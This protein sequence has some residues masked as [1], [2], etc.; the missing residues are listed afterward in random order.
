MNPRESALYNHSMQLQQLAYEM[1]VA[2]VHL[3]LERKAAHHKDLQART[4]SEHKA[5]MDLA[6][7]IPGLPDDFFDVKED[8][9]WI[10]K[11]K[12]G[13]KDLFYKHL[14]IECHHWS[15]KTGQA[16]LNKK[17]LVDIIG[18]DHKL[19]SS[20]AQHMM[21]F[22]QWQKLDSTYAV[23]LKPTIGAILHPMWS[24]GLKTT[25]RW[26][27]SPNMQNVPYPIYDDEGNVT[28]PGLRDIFCAPK[29]KW[30]VSA[31]YSAL[32]LRIIAALSGDEPLLTA[33]ANGE[34]VHAQTM[35]IMFGE[36]VDRL[37]VKEKKR[38]RVLTKT[39][40]YAANYMSSLKTIWGQILP[41]FPDTPLRLIEFMH[42]KWF[43]A[44]PIIV[45]WQNKQLF[46]A[47]RDRYTESPINKHRFYHYLNKIKP[48]ICCNFPVQSEAARIMNEAMLRVRKKLRDNEKIIINAHDEMVLQGPE[49]MRLAKLLKTCMEVEVEYNGKKMFYEVEPAIGKNWGEME[50][51]KV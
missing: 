42:N 7:E 2:G 30:L 36:T 40:T 14:D 5:F 39:F 31:D 16:S 51:V 15:A 4:V 19:G 23:G 47:R 49:P 37:S 24:A 1:S 38:K 22:N 13:P 8:K 43:A 29:D 44:H 45:E 35:R 27:S 33:Y 32:E 46:D 10:N 34:D 9:W 50:D 28:R 21:L 48:T 18:G 25:M 20:L 6:K 26:G 41:D 11:Q 3:D 17:A 12:S